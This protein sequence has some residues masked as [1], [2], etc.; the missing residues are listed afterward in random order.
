[1]KWHR[2]RSLRDPLQGRPSPNR[3]TQKRKK[4][5]ELRARCSVAILKIAKLRLR[6]FESHDRSL[7]KMPAHPTLERGQPDSWRDG[8]VQMCRMF[9]VQGWVTPTNK[10]WVLLKVTWHNN[11]RDWI[12]IIMRSAYNYQKLS[13][14]Q[15]ITTTTNFYLHGRTSTVYDSKCTN[16]WI[17]VNVWITIRF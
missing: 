14:E 5:W 3:T 13:S 12:R 7:R 8:P 4:K 2:L 15:S 1:M 11:K 17:R 10:E 16:V 6:L 9:R